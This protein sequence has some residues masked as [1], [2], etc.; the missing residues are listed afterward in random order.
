M[1]VTLYGTVGSRLLL[2][3]FARIRVN[4]WFVGQV[5]LL[6]HVLEASC[7]W[8][9]YSEDCEIVVWIILL[10]KLVVNLAVSI[11]LLVV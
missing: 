2:F 3:L 1:G 5:H 7:F 8:I 9:T 6:L 4:L 11:K 10:F